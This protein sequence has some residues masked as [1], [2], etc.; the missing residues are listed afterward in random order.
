MFVAL[1][2]FS[3][4]LLIFS[5]VGKV[6]YLFLSWMSPELSQSQSMA[7]VAKLMLSEPQRRMASSCRKSEQAMDMTALL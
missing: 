7:L 5:N 2:T 3:S 4:C 6:V 1:M